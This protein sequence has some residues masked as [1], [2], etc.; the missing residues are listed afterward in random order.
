MVNRTYLKMNKIPYPQYLFRCKI[1]K[2]LLVIFPQ[3]QFSISLKSN[4]FKHSKIISFN[5]YKTTQFIFDEVRLGFMQE[6]TLEDVKGIL[7]DK[8]RQ[9]IKHINLYEWETNKW[10]EKELQDRIGEIDKK[11]KKLKD[12]LHNDFKVD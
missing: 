3:K 2:D 7:R 9:T 5:L 4:S 6:I 12:R 1:P 11:E 10:N 8:V